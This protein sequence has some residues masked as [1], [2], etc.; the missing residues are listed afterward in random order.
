MVSCGNDSKI[1]QE[2]GK[3]QNPTEQHKNDSS[4]VFVVPKTRT[5]IMLTSLEAQ[6]NASVK[7]F[8]AE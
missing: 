7:E 3:T 1:G 6:I 8:Y 2:S 5:D 4:Y